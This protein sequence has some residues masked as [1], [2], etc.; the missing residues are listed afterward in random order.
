MRHNMNMSTFIGTK[1]V[2]AIAMSRAAY[3]G[4]RGW[5]PPEG[6]DQNVDG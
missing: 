6:E 4:Y 5:T 3:N 2:L 1:V